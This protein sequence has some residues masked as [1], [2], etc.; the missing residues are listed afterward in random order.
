MM[1]AMMDG[2]RHFPPE[3]EA[4]LASVDLDMLP[5]SFRGLCYGLERW[6]VRADAEHAGEIRCHRERAEHRAHEVEDVAV[7]DQPGEGWSQG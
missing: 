6:P 4:F 2:G 1:L 7:V 3:W 5:S